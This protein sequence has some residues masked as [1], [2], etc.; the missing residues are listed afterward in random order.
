MDVVVCTTDDAESEKE[1]SL[2]G[3]LRVDPGPSN[4]ESI[5][6]EIEKFKQIVDI[7]LPENLFSSVP[8]LVI[9]K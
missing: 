5:L 4:F 7:S 8:S 2:F 3:G 6:T 1:A 9:Q